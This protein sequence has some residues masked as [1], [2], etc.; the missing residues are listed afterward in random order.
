[1][2]ATNNRSSAISFILR[3]KY[4]EVISGHEVFE[5]SVLYKLGVLISSG[6]GF[7]DTCEESQFAEL[8]FDDALM[9]RLSYS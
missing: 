6:P 9:S 2:V 5:N 3:L 4:V 1:M 7:L 8:L